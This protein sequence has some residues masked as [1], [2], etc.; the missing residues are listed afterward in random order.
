MSHTDQKISRVLDHRKVH[1]KCNC[2]RSAVH[3]VGIGIPVSRTLSEP[4]IFPGLVMLRYDPLKPNPFLFK[5]LAE[6]FQRRCC[7]LSGHTTSPEPQR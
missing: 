5:P 3:I 6:P 1:F 4:H 7:K 2:D